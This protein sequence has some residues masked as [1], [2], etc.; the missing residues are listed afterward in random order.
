MQPHALRRTQTLALTSTL[1]RI[2]LELA[3]IDR[4]VYESIE[5]RVACHPSE[6][7]DQLA[8]VP[9]TLFT[10]PHVSL[11]LTSTLALLS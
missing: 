6:S 8:A 5:L 11:L 10:L 4:S 3:D 7:H 9:Y 1:F 2:Q